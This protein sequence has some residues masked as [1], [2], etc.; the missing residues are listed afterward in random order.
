[1]FLKYLVAAAAALSLTAC[2]GNDRCTSA[3]NLTECRK[4]TDAGGDVDD[5][6]VGGMAGFLI[7]QQLS[8]GQNRTY[9]YRDPGYHGTYRPMRT[10]IGSRDQ[11]I[12]RLE[13]KVQR[14]KLEL[15]RQQ[16]A[17]A[18][19]ASELRSIKASKSPF[20]FRSSSKSSRSWGS[21][22]PSRRK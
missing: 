16:A 10:P 11:Q 5:Y 4:W 2:A 3:E 7:G 8:G 1:M 12:R 14:Q 20:S 15:K 6:L 19:K 18:R 22:R 9:I 17:N 13:R 21:S